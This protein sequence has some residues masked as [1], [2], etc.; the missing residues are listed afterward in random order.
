MEQIRQIRKR[1]E[2][3]L[4]ADAILMQMD[5]VQM[6]LSSHYLELD[7]NLWHLGTFGSLAQN[8]EEVRPK[9][10]KLRKLLSS[11]IPENT[12]SSMVNCFGRRFGNCRIC[13]QFP[14]FPKWAFER[15]QQQ[16][17]QFPQ[18]LKCSFERPQQRPEQFPQFQ[19][20]RSHSP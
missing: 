18:F 16:L 3:L 4:L 1:L 19:I 8:R 10:Q 5:A 7:S 13:W 12:V 9:L 20:R 2:K 11:R 17:E 6:Q 15:L 14:Q